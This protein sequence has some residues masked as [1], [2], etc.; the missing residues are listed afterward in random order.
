MKNFLNLIKRVGVKFFNDSCF[1]RA[2]GLAFSTLLAMVPFITIIY[3]FGGFDTLG[4]TIESVL[5]KA[6]IPA[7]HEAV[8]QALNAFTRNSLATG[9]LGTIFFLMTSMF[10]INTI[11]RNF[12][13]IWGVFSNTHFFRKYATYAAVL[14]FGSLLLGVSNSISGSIENYILSIGIGEIDSFREVLSLTFPF[15]LTLI[16][17]WGM[18]TIIPS[19]KVKLKAAAFGA[20][21]SAV[22][23]E[24]IKV[25]FK[26]WVVN[27]VKISLIYGSVAVI[28]VFLVGLYLFWL[29]ILIGVEISYIVQNDHNPIYGAPEQLNMEEKICFGIELFL[30]VAMSYKNS[31]GGITEKELEKK[32]ES[33]PLIINSILSLFLEDNLILNINSKKGGYIPGRSLDSLKLSDIVDSIY[34]G[35]SRIIS[36][37]E[38]SKLNSTSF[39][40]G[41]YNSLD[42]LSI[43]EIIKM[44][45][46]EKN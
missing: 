19:S 44:S 37:S 32:L 27:S 13:A 16:I 20:I 29:I 38:I 39:T 33:S 1:I 42:Q 10:L 25:V 18:L 17:F 14:V 2:S 8:S 6:I 4:K 45:E 23:F 12:D 35:S 15:V 9:T 22:L 43:L 3:T 28:P 34:G 21:T 7:Q 41:G 24:I 36:G 31:H 30:Q 26:Y 46:V 11:A 5:L 40:K